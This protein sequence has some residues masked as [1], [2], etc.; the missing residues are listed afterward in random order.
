[1]AC[2]FS[3]IVWG[4]Y[5]PFSVTTN[6]PAVFIL[7]TETVMRPRYQLQYTQE[8]FGESIAACPEKT[9]LSKVT[10]DPGRYFAHPEYHSTSIRYS[11]TFLHS[12][13]RLP[14]RQP[15]GTALSEL[16]GLPGGD[17][18]EN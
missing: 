12:T 4:P 2:G 15:V 7:S 6:K 8:L 11:R 18:A 9:N 3:H 17:G 13:G 5:R 10:R 1:M 16:D 14:R